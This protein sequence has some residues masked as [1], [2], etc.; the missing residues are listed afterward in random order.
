[1]VLAPKLFKDNQKIIKVEGK[2]TKEHLG[3]C[4][5]TRT[6]TIHFIENI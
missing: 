2:R 1:M 3:E 4:L 6:V 5:E